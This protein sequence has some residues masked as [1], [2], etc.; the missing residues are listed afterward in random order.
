MKLEEMNIPLGHKLKIFKKIEQI[1]N[2]Q[3]DE[4]ENANFTDKKE[5]LEKEL[6]VIKNHPNNNITK[7]KVEISSK[8]SK[9]VGVIPEETIISEDEIQKESLKLQNLGERE[10]NFNN[11]FDE[12]G[13][14]VNENIESLLEKDESS[15]LKS[16]N[17]FNHDH[18][19]IELKDECISCWQCFSIKDKIK[20]NELKE[21]V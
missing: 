8:H 3:I 15:F 16:Q 14:D 9:G 5:F 4:N 2:I 6:S 17:N 19:N 1:K 18:N 10:F 7:R 11:L 21:K 13:E 20:M 12:E